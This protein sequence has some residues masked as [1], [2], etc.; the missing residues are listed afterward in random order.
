MPSILSFMKLAAKPPAAASRPIVNAVN[1]QAQA[2]GRLHPG[3]LAQLL[4]RNPGAVDTLARQGVAIPPMP[5]TVDGGPVRYGLGTTTMQMPKGPTVSTR[6]MPPAD[7][8]KPFEVQMPPAAASPPPVPAAPG[9]P[10]GGLGSRLL[11]GGL[12]T[13][14]GVGLGAGLRHGL[15]SSP[16]APPENPSPMQAEESEAE[17][18][19]EAP[20]EPTEDGAKEACDLAFLGFHLLEQCQDPEEPF[21]KAANAGIPAATV[22]QAHELA[23]AAPTL[24]GMLAR[25]RQE[26]VPPVDAM[27]LLKVAAARLPVLQAE[28]QA[29]AGLV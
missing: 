4:G 11:L 18:D 27:R 14:G 19:S 5:K 15:G 21:R 2:T 22:H 8:G 1:Q 23:N 16:S 9:K 17:G 10:G 29:V 26:G 7:S 13:V 24:C 3:D 20:A 25:C 6:Q 28:I 12:G